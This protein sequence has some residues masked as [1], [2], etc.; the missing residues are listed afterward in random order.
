MNALFLFF[1]AQTGG[2]HWGSLDLILL[3]LLVVAAIVGVNGFFVATEF[4]IVKLRASQLDPLIEEGDRRAILARHI[5]THLDSYL[6]ATQLGITMTSLA[7]GWV[8]EPF[9]AHM[10]EPLFLMVGIHSETVVTTASIVLGFSI[11]T[12]LH[13]IL[14]ELGPKYLAIRNPLGM[15]L[16]VVRGLGLFYAVFRP[17]I[18]CLNMS[19]NFLLKSVFKIDPVSKSELAHSEEELRV[20]LTESEQAEEVSSL[21]KEILINALDLR[22]R[23]VRDIMT[24]R[25]EV[26]FLNTENSFE[27][28]LK[29]AQQSLH[30]RFPLCDGHLD[31]T[32]GQVHIKDIFSLVR[33]QKPDLLGIKREVLPVPEMMPLEKL[34]KFFLTRHAHLALVVD[35]YG[36]TVGIVSLDNVL[37]ELVGDIQ[38]EF[39]TEHQEFRKISEDEFS[40][41]GSIGLYELND[42]AGLDLESS[43]VS[44]VGGYV[45]H[46]LGHLPKQGEQ[47]RIGEYEVT[48]T[49]TDGRRVGQLHFKKTT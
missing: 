4:A 46:L 28:N 12:F 11:I 9:V 49:Q 47:T 39:D 23:V 8:G 18:W 32:V 21:G 42:L 14:G 10:I 43:D 5:T 25:G 26:V 45:T 17:I 3:K 22:R 38:D 16:R 27:E 34:L 36:G 48:I 33:G 24:P 35:E 31:N 30:T 19:S 40:V 37:A 13:I 15:S 7:L 20:I 6:S 2:N 41:E 44:T 1:V 29:V